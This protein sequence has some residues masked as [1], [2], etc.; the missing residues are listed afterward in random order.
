SALVPCPPGGGPPTPEPSIILPCVTPEPT[1]SHGGGP[2]TDPPGPTPTKGNGGP[3][4]TRT[5]TLTILPTAIERVLA[6]AGI[7][8]AAAF[9]LLVPLVGLV[10]GRRFRPA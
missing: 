6:E 1:E 10:L 8:P 2:P 5:P 9:P 7:P 4:P 3:K